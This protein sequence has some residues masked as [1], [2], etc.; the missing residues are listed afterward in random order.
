M[1]TRIPD[2]DLAKIRRYAEGCVP[3]HARH[4]LHYGI[5]VRGAAV[6][7]IERRAPWRADN[8]AEW[9]ARPVAQLRWN[10]SP[11]TWTLYWP[12]R[13]S[14]WHPYPHTPATSD[15]DALLTEIDQDTT[16]AFR[17]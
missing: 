10:P 12:D 14:R 1:S 2:L 11:A 5:A 6:T 17:G 7:I 15:V 3:E 8:D 16:G 13:R 4:Q 9:T